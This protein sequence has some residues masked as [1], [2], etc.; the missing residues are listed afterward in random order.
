MFPAQWKCVLLVV[1]VLS[2]SVLGAERGVAH[3]NP[4]PKEDSWCWSEIG[5]VVGGG[6]AAVAA[7]PVVLSAAGFGAGG[8]AAG[9]LAAKGM[10]LAAT[11]GV[12]GSVIGAAQSAGAAGIGWM[13]SAGLV[14]GG[15]AAGKVASEAMG[16]CQVDCPNCPKTCPQK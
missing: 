13:A 11:Y 2:A 16:N 8:I 15:V 7:A 9:S 10:S 5:M 3:Y 6:I 1:L 14:A 4:P 12:G